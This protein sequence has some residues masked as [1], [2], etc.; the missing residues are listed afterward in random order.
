MCRIS[1]YS[2]VM[3]GDDYLKRSRKKS[4]YLPRDAQNQLLPDLE[5]HQTRV[6]INA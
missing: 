6:K 1:Y 4:S 5:K 3:V 2:S